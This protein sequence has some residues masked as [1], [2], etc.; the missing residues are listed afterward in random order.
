[1]AG[2][3]PIFI[4]TVLPRGYC[5]R[6][7]T[8]VY[9]APAGISGDMN[10]GAMVD[11]GVDPEGLIAELNK[12][13]LSGWSMTF[14]RDTR[15]GVEGTLCTVT[16]DEDH[17]HR[18]FATIRDL[19]ET[20]A[21]DAAVKA[22]AVAVFRVLAEAE[23]AVH[24]MPP[25][26]V[27]FH[28][29]GAVDSI[30]DI[31]GAALCR[32]RLGIDRIV[33]SGLELGSGAV[34][35]AHGVMPVPAPATA[36][37]VEGLP[38]SAGGVPGEATTPTGAAILVGLG[39]DFG[40]PAQ[41]T[42]VAT[43]VGLGRREVPG[44]ANA[45]HVMLVEDSEAPA[46]GGSDE[47]VELAANL[48][49]LS[50]EHVAFLTETLLAAGALD[51]WQTPAVFKKGRMGCVVHALARPAD[52]VAL[53]DL[54]FRH[55]TTLGVRRQTWRRTVMARS[56]DTRTTPLGEVR[57]KTARRGEVV[58]AKPAYDDLRRLARESGRS[59]AEIETLLKDGHGKSG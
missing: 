6:M 31:V 26:K 48:D 35:C 47:V 45:L 55:S 36:R 49:D 1:M 5:F 27:H 54:F 50:P 28:E 13:G 22:D 25:E 42:V 30:V 15:H 21:L 51:V 39:A 16:C 37:L 14:T 43:G 33:V 24:G 32:R 40:R 4:C 10:L 57:V 56:E 34:T 3:R 17:H 2:A 8:L 9:N 11:L 38:V 19:I 46:H 59:L 18:T 23:G 52:E 29:V 58:R 7:R 53:T 44:A 20:S 41:G 12:L